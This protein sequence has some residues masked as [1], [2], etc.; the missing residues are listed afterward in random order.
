MSDVDSLRSAI[1]EALGRAQGPVRAR[2]IVTYL[3]RRGWEHDNL[4]A[5][6]SSHL[7]SLRAKG[8]VRNRRIYKGDL[9][10]VRGRWR[11][12]PESH[13]AWFLP[14]VPMRAVYRLRHTIVAGGSF[15]SIPLPSPRT[16]DMRQM[17]ADFRQITQESHHG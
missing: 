15:P 8:L 11:L 6:V 1:L 4:M 7:G 17:L 13:V 9:L 2:E 16:D 10:P 12:Y 5:R 3:R 14:S